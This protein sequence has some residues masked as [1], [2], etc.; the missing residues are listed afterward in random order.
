MNGARKTTQPAFRR[1][2][3]EVAAHGPYSEKLAKN[4]CFGDMYTRDGGNFFIQMDDEPKKMDFGGRIGVE[5]TALIENPI[6]FYR[7]TPHVVCLQL[8]PVAHDAILAAA[9]GGRAVTTREPIYYS[10]DIPYHR[11]S[12]EEFFIES[13]N[14]QK[15]MITAAT[16]DEYLRPAATASSPADAAPQ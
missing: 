5:V 15:I 2:S 6:T 11:I 12:D 13:E 1:Y 7:L 9:A 3:G 10:Y 4:L 14:G 16:P 8:D